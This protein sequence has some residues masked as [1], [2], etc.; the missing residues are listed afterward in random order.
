M[1]LPTPI[2]IP[3]AHPYGRKFGAMPLPTPIIHPYCP[4][5]W[6]NGVV[7]SF[8]KNTPKKMRKVPFPPF[9]FV[10]LEFRLLDLNLRRF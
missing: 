10:L 2:T 9:G 6:P 3:I 5:L 4:S 1:P 8:S 7:T